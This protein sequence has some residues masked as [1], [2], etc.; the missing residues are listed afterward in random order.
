MRYGDM[1]TRVTF[2]APYRMDRSSIRIL[3]AGF[4]AA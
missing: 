3:L 1:V 2:Y 4:R